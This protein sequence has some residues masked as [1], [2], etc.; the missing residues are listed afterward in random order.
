MSM[1]LSDLTYDI[2]QQETILLSV[3]SVII[4]SSDRIIKLVKLENDLF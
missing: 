3:Q 1:I 2:Y 4:S